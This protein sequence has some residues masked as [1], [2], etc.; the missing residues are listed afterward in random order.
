M[1]TST[2]MQET[3]EDDTKVFG[4]FLSADYNHVW[5]QNLEEFRFASYEERTG[6]STRETMMYAYNVGMAPC[7][8]IVAANRQ[9]LFR[10]IITFFPKMIW[11]MGFPPH[12][13]CRYNGRLLIRVSHE[14]ED[15]SEAFL[16]WVRSKGFVYKDGV[17]T[18]DPDQVMRRR[19]IG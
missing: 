12:E 13:Y 1:R 7:G 9:D 8:G 11:E 18:P 2:W 14:G 19:E 3:G 4:S 6:K 5:I 15:C 17:V 16:H 10:K